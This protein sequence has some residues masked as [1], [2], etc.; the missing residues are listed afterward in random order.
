[1]KYA[2]LNLVRVWP[3]ALHRS[4]VSL[5][6]TDGF[7]CVL[8]EE[9]Q[10]LCPHGLTLHAPYPGRRSYADGLRL[11]DLL[12]FFLSGLNQQLLQE[13]SLNIHT[14]SCGA[15]ARLCEGRASTTASCEVFYA[16][17]PTGV[18]F[19]VYHRS[20]AVLRFISS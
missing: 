5:L 6:K 2:V 13:G 14:Q 18:C 9:I 19:K 16:L 3:T 4:S 10:A 8:S 12:D 1:M 15:R 17:S 7:L 11:G 20:T